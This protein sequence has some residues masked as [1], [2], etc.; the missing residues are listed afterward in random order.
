MGIIQTINSG[1]DVMF[2]PLLSLP[3]LWAIFTIAI[4]LSILVTLLYKR[5]T[6]Q[7]LMKTLKQDIKALQQEMKKLRDKPDKMME[8]NKR[9]M[10]KN[11]KYMMHSLKPTLVTF[12]PMILIIGWISS[13][14]AV[15][16]ISPGESFTLYAFMDDVTINNATIEVPEGVKLLS[17]TTSDIIR[18]DNG[19]DQANL[20]FLDA[21][22]TKPGGVLA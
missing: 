16:T 11:M 4:L 19:E 22:L 5:L 14:Y 7:E 3:P 13:H 20:P 9:A 15:A 21:S 2:S 8:V 17:S 1:L 18:I 6:D 10:E 12:L